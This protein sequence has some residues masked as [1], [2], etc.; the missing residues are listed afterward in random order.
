MPIA[1]LAI[2]ECHLYDRDIPPLTEEHQAAVNAVNRRQNCVAALTQR[3]HLENYIHAQAIHRARGLQI[4]FVPDDDLPELVAQYSYELLGGQHR[5]VSFRR[6]CM[7][8]FQTRGIFRLPI[9]NTGEDSR[10][11][12]AR[13][14][15]PM[16]ASKTRSRSAG[17]EGVR[18]RFERWRRSHRARSRIP[19]SLWAAA[20]R[21]A[22]THGIHRTCRTLRLDYYSLKERVEQRSAA[23]SDPA[24]RTVVGQ[25]RKSFRQGGPSAPAF[26]ELAPPALTGS[27]ECTLELEDPAGSK[28]RV[29]LKSIAMPDLAALSRSFWNPSP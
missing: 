14:G 4:E 3:R 26:L 8:D 21:M 5:W 27:C 7:N 28:M 17:L 29:H 1:P 20:V 10:W 18:R 16:G 2:P 24:E 15:Q 11:V 23:A 6:A 19:T 13:R 25:R 22:A 12:P 9:R